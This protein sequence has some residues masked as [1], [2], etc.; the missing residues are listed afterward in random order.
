[1]TCKNCQKR[2]S[3]YLDQESS[4]AER[5]VIEQHI[6]ECTDCAQALRDLQMLVDQATALPQKH[7]PDRLW[8]RI[9]SELDQPNVSRIHDTVPAWRNWLRRPMPVVQLGFAIAILVVGMLVGRYILPPQ[10]DTLRL[11]VSQQSPAELAALKGKPAMVLTC[12]PWAMMDAVAQICIQAGV[13]SYASLESI[14][15]CGYGVCNGCV[16]RVKADTDEGFRYAKTCVE[17]TVM[18]CSKLIW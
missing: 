5:S 2:L 13:P 16:A 12:G 3:A 14:M 18:D 8:G 7:A 9:A 1:M 10:S 4:P 15:A 17:G 6:S 11:Q